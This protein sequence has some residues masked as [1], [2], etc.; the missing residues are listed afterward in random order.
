M[1][2]KGSLNDAIG[3]YVEYSVANNIKSNSN[4]LNL[5]NQQKNIIINNDPNYNIKKLDDNSKNISDKIISYIREKRNNAAIVNIIL[6]GAA[7]DFKSINELY[8]NN[9]PSDILLELNSFGL[10]EYQKYLGVSIKNISLKTKGTV[11][12]NPG[13]DDLLKFLGSS[14]SSL[15]DTI[16][17]VV[18]KKYK[19]PPLP[20]NKKWF[21]KKQINNSNR[22][23]FITAA[24]DV[25]IRYRDEIF[26]LLQK[27]ITIDSAG[28]KNYIIEK[29]LRLTSLPFYIVVTPN[30]NPYESL[31]DEQVNDILQSNM[32]VSKN[33]NFS[34]FI[35]KN[36]TNL[37]SIGIKFSSS[38]DMTNS[39]KLRVI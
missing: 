18:I 12:I 32:T 4:F 25:K 14:N 24:N 22:T 6:T 15:Y 5:I 9:N 13:V 19:L 8:D 39:I 37:F 35:K 26:K 38:S 27:K 36:T 11:K 30:R 16:V 31:F 7:F 10:S 17:P 29:L 23:Q 33:A 2:T 20:K 34:I 1:A 3:K 21:D 28:F